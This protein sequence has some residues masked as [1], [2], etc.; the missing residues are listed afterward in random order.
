MMEHRWSRLVALFERAVTLPL[1][2]REA[3]LA[4]LEAVLELTR[5][6]P[7]IVELARL[8]PQQV[9]DADPAPVVNREEPLLGLSF[10]ERDGLP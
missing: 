6:G 1:A 3:F 9:V 2:E 7:R 5:I 4:A 8:G 10:V